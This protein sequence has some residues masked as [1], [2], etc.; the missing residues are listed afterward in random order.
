[1]K[2][3]PLLIAIAVAELATGVGLLVVPSTV[4]EL[5]LGQPLDPGAPLVVGRVAGIALIAI[6]LMC[7][8]EKT[9][10]RGGS[11]T[12]LLIGLL[13]YNGAVPVLLVHSYMTLGTNGIGLW[14]VVALHFVFTA[15]LAACLRSTQSGTS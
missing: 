10:T 5:L 3:T 12:G 7:W 2:T 6:G 14:P 9:S 8:L 13:V 15:L 11:L 4:V 1:M